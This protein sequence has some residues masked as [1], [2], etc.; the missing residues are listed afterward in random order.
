M[1]S[2]DSGAKMRIV[3]IAVVAFMVCV[4]VALTVI[5]PV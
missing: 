5:M 2:K 1:S 4:I 3:N